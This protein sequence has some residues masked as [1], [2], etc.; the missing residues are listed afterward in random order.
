MYASDPMLGYTAPMLRESLAAR[1]GYTL[2][3]SSGSL[4]L[5]YAIAPLYRRLVWQRFV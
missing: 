3:F 1:Y 2:R 4:L 5:L